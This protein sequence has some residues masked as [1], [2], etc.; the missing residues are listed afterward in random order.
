MFECYRLCRGQLL[1]EIKRLGPSHLRIAGA[2]TN[3]LTLTQN[4]GSSISNS[5]MQISLNDWKRLYKMI[6]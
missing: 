6:R 3:K 4:A 2:S 5:Q 1:R